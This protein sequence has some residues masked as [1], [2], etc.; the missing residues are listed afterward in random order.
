MSEAIQRLRRVSDTYEEK[1]TESPAMY[2][3]AARAEAYYRAERAKAV[4]RHKA[5]ADRMSVAEAE[6]RADADNQIYQL[7]TDRL[8]SAALAEAHKDRLRQLK[9]RE[10]SCRTEVTTEREADRIHAVRGDRP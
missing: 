1:A 6:T 5:S 10:A 3:T 4:L 7:H 2:E 9:E 8:V